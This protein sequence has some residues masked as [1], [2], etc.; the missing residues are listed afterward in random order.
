MCHYITN[1]N[2]NTNTKTPPPLHLSVIIFIIF[3]KTIIHP[4]HVN[5][6]VSWFKNLIVLTWATGSILLRFVKFCQ[7][8]ANLER[9]TELLYCNSF[10]LTL[11][12]GSRGQGLVGSCDW[13]LDCVPVLRGID[14][15]HRPEL[16]RDGDD[17]DNVWYYDPHWCLMMMATS[18]MMILKIAQP[19]QS[20][21]SPG[22]P[23]SSA[24]APGLH[25]SMFHT[26]NTL[27]SLKWL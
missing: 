14:I 26:N 18:I 6:H 1:T 25:L 3:I 27:C 8:F 13:C 19:F 2:T 15:T 10:P 16:H 20:K 24:T 5:I 12:R 7:K 11:Y 4:H 9:S 17:G 22:A 21:R 23:P